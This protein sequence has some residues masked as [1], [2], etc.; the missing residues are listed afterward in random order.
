MSDADLR[1]QAIEAEVA[2]ARTQL[3]ASVDELTHR[4]DPKEA[5]RRH[6]SAL[7]RVGAGAAAVLIVLVL[8]ARRRARRRAG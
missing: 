3:Q 2:Q 6:Q 7:I 8:L 5:A 1:Q 4:L